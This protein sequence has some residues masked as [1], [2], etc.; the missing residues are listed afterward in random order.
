MKLA[1][2]RARRLGHAAGGS[3]SARRLSHIAARIGGSASA[4][5]GREFHGPHPLWLRS[6][7]ADWLR[8]QLAAHGAIGFRG[9]QFASPD[10]LVDFACNFGEPVDV[11]G[12]PVQ[13]YVSDGRKP[14]PPEAP[15]AA[16]GSDLFHSD[17]SYNAKPAAVTLLYL[18]EGA[19][20]TCTHLLDA[21]YAFETLSDDL[22]ERDSGMPDGLRRSVCEA[23]GVD[24]LSDLPE[25]L[26]AV[27]DAR[28]AAAPATATHPLARA[29]PT[30]GKP[31]LYISPLYTTALRGAKLEPAAKGHQAG[32]AERLLAQ[33][34]D[35]MLL[36]AHQA[37]WEWQAPGDLLVI[38]NARMLHRG[39]TR[40]MARGLQ[41][42]MLRV[43][44]AGEEPVRWRRTRSWRRAKAPQP[45]L[46]PV[47]I[48]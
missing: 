38:D 2:A 27:H 36:E 5:I 33:L 9:I 22:K 23:L 48:T 17:N 7:P 29:H 30:T 16:R 44:I 12:K 40:E 28:S 11:Q 41:R 10:E 26:S 37:P 35:H 21:Q 8:E 31:S 19:H 15:P 20:S 43:S 14:A 42:R 1:A 34:L 24:R 32:P 6:A 39:T 46:D 13:L 3:A 18:L 45:F 47:G 25:G 4:P